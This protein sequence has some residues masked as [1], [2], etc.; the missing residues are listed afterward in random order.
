MP[1]KLNS[2]SP[3]FDAQFQALVADTRDVES[4]V[5]G[6]VERIIADVR[7]RGDAALFDLTD[8][9]DKVTYTSETVR[10]DPGAM[11]KFYAQCR[12]E[13][14]EALKV[15]KSRIEA[16]HRH[17]MPSDFSF[18]DDV[19]AH[20]GA[21]WTP[22]AAAGI[23]VPGGLASYPS[24][25]LMNAVPAKV[26]GVGRI[27]MTVPS[28]G[29]ALSPLVVAA[30][31]IA[32]VDEIYKV[33]GAQAVAAL[34]YGTETIQPVDKIFGPGNSY[35]AEAKRQVFGQ[36]G[37]DM[38]A[39]PSEILVV[40]DSSAR[41]DWTAI[42]L[43]SQA[44]H[45]PTAQSILITDD[46]TF[47]DAVIAAVEEHLKH[48]ATQETARQ[49]WETYGAVI[50]CGDLHGDAPALIDALA[51]EHLMLACRDP[52]R[53]FDAVQHAGSAFIGHFTPEAAGDYLA[54][55]NHVL[56][57]SRRARFSSGLS[58]LDFMKRTTFLELSKGALD[59]IGP[60]AVT[61][62]DAEGLS[63]HARSLA[64]RIG[65]E[66]AGQKTAPDDTT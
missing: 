30:A 15:A 61:L 44:E 9:F 26:A 53:L 59:A 35:V 23:Y 5:S 66:P 17:S 24:S 48:L 14:L 6:V 8:Q 19:G 32:G 1:L 57:T 43:L 7:R 51:P 2:Q 29:G 60:A 52:H 22:I 38:I 65:Q 58:V 12:E 55:P 11:E 21:R 10:I 42:D 28:P 36:V 63:A 20:L 47:A 41:P 45:D 33:G 64:V 25:V 27:V 31:H 54:G 40:A 56:P 18:T 39:G 13:E 37:I 46:E 49:S 50:L 34:A 4:D 3:D 62:A 16:F